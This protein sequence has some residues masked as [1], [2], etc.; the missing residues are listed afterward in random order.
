MQLHIFYL[1]LGRDD[2]HL[3]SLPVSFTVNFKI[4]SLALNAKALQYVS[5]GLS[6][7]GL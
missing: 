2:L 7:S 3:Y 5:L 1:F 4:P 6:P